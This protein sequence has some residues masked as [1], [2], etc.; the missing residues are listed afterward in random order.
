M[1]IIGICGYGG[2]G[3]SAVI[4]LLKEFEDI[5]V[6]NDEFQIIHE[7]DGITSLYYSIVS[8]S[9]FNFNVSAK[10][11][12]KKMKNKLT[13]KNSKLYQLLDDYIE[14]L[15]QIVW[16]G[17]SEIDPNDIS[18]HYPPILWKLFRFIKRIF[19]KILKDIYFP[20]GNKRYYSGITTEEFINTSKTFLTNYFLLLGYK[21]NDTLVIDQLFS[22]TNILFE[23][24]LFDNAKAII[25]DRDPRDI[26]IDSKYINSY[27]F[28]PQNNVYDFVLFQ[29]VVRN[30]IENSIMGENIIRINF[31]DL[32]LNYEN[33]VELISKFLSVKK[34]SKKGAYFI[35]EKSRKNIFIY[36]RF[37]Q[38][39]SEI[40]Y[41]A[42]NSNSK[43][44]YKDGGIK[45]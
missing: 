40:N 17:Y 39:A 10:R 33:T 6:L 28:I 27:R 45:E 14:N 35:P 29:N 9:M 22:A 18:I 43:H 5:K 36:K 16:Y 2:T 31:E 13:D 23:M 41:I 21:I 19:S 1:N 25:V 37:E 24:S 7:P 38:Y 15:S 20:F 3:S 34:H 44:L 12:L 4:D 8:K 32:I 42:N 30:I 26:Y 11:F